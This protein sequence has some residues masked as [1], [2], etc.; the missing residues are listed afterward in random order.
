MVY[1]KNNC[2]EVE[3]LLRDTFRHMRE[4]FAKIQ[5]RVGDFSIVLGGGYGRG[6]GGVLTDELTN[7]KKLYND[8]DFFVFFETMSSKNKNLLNKLLSELA[9]KWSEKLSIDV[10]FAQAR[11]INVIPKATQKTLMYQEL[12]CGHEVIFGNSHILN[13]LTRIASCDL[14]ILEGFR[15]MLNRGTGLFLAK[16]KYASD[17]L[18]YNFIWRN[19]HKCALGAGDAYL[20]INHQYDYKIEHRLAKLEKILSKANF[21]LYENAVK[22]KFSPEII[23]KNQ[24]VEYII[25]VEAFWRKNLLLISSCNSSAEL[26]KKL[27]SNEITRTFNLK[28]LLLNI[29]YR[30]RVNSLVGFCEYPQMLVLADLLECM[31]GTMSREKFLKHWHRFN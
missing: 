14:P 29:L 23:G 22:F 24:I 20:I 2:P 19:L 30:N 25:Q 8:L 10:D 1:T 9:E 7:T 12:L 31:D 17:E 21:L 18:D 26:V 4:E 27:R 16:E 15:L 11:A 3:K 13:S 6:D 5:M 28:N